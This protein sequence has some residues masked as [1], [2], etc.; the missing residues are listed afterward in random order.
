MASLSVDRVV[1]GDVPLLSRE[2]KV[3]FIKN[4]SA[5]NQLMFN[6]HVTDAEN[7]KV[8]RL[9]NKSRSS[10]LNSISFT[11]YIRVQPSKGILGV[12]ESKMCK[13]TFLSKN[14]PSFYNIDLICEVSLWSAIGA[15]SFIP[16][17]WFFS[18]KIK[19]VNEINKYKNALKKW[20][21][22]QRRLWEEF[23][24]DDR[25]LENRIVILWLHI[26]LIPYHFFS[27]QLILF[28]FLRNRRL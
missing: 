18:F 23:K 22:D 20:E 27:T 12:N 5:Q 16:T 21:V 13:I 26:K 24:I 6:W 3:V 10:N 28:F 4:N 9:S 17:E 2:R 15:R 11:Q 8:N 1:F 19:N 25:E 14:S 7:V